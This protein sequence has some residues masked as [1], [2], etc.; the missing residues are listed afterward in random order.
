MKK[1]II[2]AVLASLVFVLVSCGST[3][4]EEMETPVADTCTAT[5]DTVKCDTV[6]VEKV[7]TLA[8]AK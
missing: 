5:C 1:Y 7:D 3:A 4:V 2:T 8:K 6:V